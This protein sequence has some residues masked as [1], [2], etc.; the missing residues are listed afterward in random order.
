M[1]HLSLITGVMGLWGRWLSLCWWIITLI[2]VIVSVIF[3]AATS[4]NSNVDSS[5]GFKFFS[6]ERPRASRGRLFSEKRARARSV[7][8]L[9]F[10]LEMFYGVLSRLALIGNKSKARVSP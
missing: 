6:R 9:R 7:A 2:D 5:R 8:A 10:D 4:R 3:A 1:Y